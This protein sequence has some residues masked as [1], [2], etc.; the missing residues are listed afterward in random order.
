MRVIVT[1]AGGPA[2]V[3]V[4]DALRGAETLV[5]ADA[6]P[7]AIGLRLAPEA[8]VL[9][10]CTHPDFL[11]AIINAGQ[12][13]AALIVTVAE[14][15]LV[16]APYAKQLAA[17]GVLTWLPSTAA[18]DRCLDKWAFAETLE[19]SGVAAPRTGL[20]SADGV[21]GPWVV[22]PRFG[23][24]SR[25]VMYVGDRAELRYA[26]KRVPDA[27]VQTQLDGREFTADALVSAHGR[28]L[29]VVPRWRLETRGGISTRGETF[30][31]D[32]V[33]RAVA[34]T[35]EAVGMTGPANVQGF[36]DSDGAVWIMEVNPRFS[37]GLPL[38]LAAGAD[39]VGQYLR[40][41]RGLPIDES[42]LAFR[43]GVRMMRRFTEV[44]E[45]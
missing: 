27:L 4:L 38:S 21:P 25:D 34:A 1:G 5:A 33:T 17:A 18:L 9:P 44:F 2:G 8:V 37:G 45:G 24:G 3:A 20:A 23:R 19:A 14:E 42:R 35:L 11:E 29:A 6:D 40:G 7:A 12:E 39:L 36:V 31:D 15:A 22:K 28:A 10:R 30:C 43:P 16:L 32:A 13:D 41:M 26:L